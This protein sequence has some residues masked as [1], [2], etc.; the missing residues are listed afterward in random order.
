MINHEELVIM[1]NICL[2]YDYY[3]EDI[4]WLQKNLN[5]L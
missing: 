2:S 1:S 5:T 3:I 4:F